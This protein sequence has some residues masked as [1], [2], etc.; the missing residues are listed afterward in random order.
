MREVSFLEKNQGVFFILK[1]E[2][3]PERVALFRNGLCVIAANTEISAIYLSVDQSFVVEEEQWRE[4]VA[5]CCSRRLASMVYFYSRQD[6]RLYLVSELT[7]WAVEDGQ[8]RV[9]GVLE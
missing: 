6:R 5:F 7:Q 1:G 8:P 3:T 4:V 9:A 2:M